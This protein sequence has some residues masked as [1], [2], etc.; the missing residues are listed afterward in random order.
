MFCFYVSARLRVCSSRV[1]SRL[2]TLFRFGAWCSDPSTHVLT[3]GF[4]TGFWHSR[5]MLCLVV[6][7]CSLE[8][9]WPHTLLTTCFVF[10]VVARSSCFYRLCAFMFCLVLSGTQLVFFI[11]CVF[12]SSFA[13]GWWFVLLAMCLC[14]CF[15]WAH[16]FVLVFCVPCALMSICLDPTHLVSWILV[17]LSHLCIPRYP[18]LLIP[19]W[20]LW[21]FH[22]ESVLSCLARL[23]SLPCTF[24][25]Y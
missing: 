11:S 6:W 21:S 16:G 22:S 12:V 3:F 5:S 2:H 9:A 23:A 20:S 17:N 19:L 24:Y 18:P 7:V 4:V 25:F 1:L 8:F 13:H 15:V 14:F 10:C